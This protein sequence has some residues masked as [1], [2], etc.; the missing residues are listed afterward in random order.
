MRIAAVADLHHEEATRGRVEAVAEA[1]CGAEADVLV[2][3]GDLA[4]SGWRDV[5]EVL[6]LF[7]DFR[8]PRLMVP[9]NHDLWEHEP[10]FDTWRVYEEI[11]PAIAS[12]HGFHYLDSEPLVLGGIAFVGCMGW[13]DYSFRQRA[14]PREGLTVTPIQVVPGEEERMA[15]SAVPGAAESDWEELEAEDYAANGLIWQGDGAP[16]VAVWNDAVHL[17]WG[18]PAPELAARFA[19]RL[20]E[21]LRAV[22]DRAERVVGVTHFV[23]FAELA[24]YH[25]ENPTR[26]FAKAY[27]GSPLL[28]KALLESEKLALVICGH[29]HRQEVREVRG[30]VTADAGIADQQV[31]PLLL[32][33]PD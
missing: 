8:G 17:D 32:M 3:A 9:G 21:H 26:A 27:L 28:G 6:A 24:E 14:A 18:R 22:A 29:R 10:P 13:Y 30:V 33:L 4:A 1:I 25:L 2:I 5:G 12:E 31:G 19:G 7:S 23:P 16:H 15:F 20:R 11:L